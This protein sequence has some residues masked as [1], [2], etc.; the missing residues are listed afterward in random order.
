LLPVR[1]PLEAD[2][3]GRVGW[4]LLGPRPDGSLYNKDERETLAEVAD[5]VARA[6]DIVHRRAARS[7]AVQEQLTAMERRFAVLEAA[8]ARLTGKAPLAG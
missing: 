1:I 2:G 3:C 8:L 6:L 7:E 5:P 4:L